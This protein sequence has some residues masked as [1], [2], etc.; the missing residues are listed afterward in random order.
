MTLKCSYVN[1]SNNAK[2]IAVIDEDIRSE[3]YL[4][5]TGTY[6]YCENHKQVAKLISAHLAQLDGE[7]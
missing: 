7:S 6:Y 4:T 2:W 3:K 5:T 1:C